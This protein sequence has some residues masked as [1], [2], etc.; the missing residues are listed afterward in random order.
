MKP[1]VGLV[2]T[3]IVLNCVG[4]T[5]F[6]ADFNSG[7]SEDS[8]GN[9][10]WETGSAGVT[11]TVDSKE[12]LLNFSWE[13]LGSSE[14]SN[15]DDCCNEICTTDYEPV[16]ASD[17]V[18]YANYC[19]FSNAQCKTIDL[20]LLALGE[21]AGG[22]LSDEDETGST[23]SLCPD[24]CRDIYDPVS[25]ENGTI[26]TNDCFM[27][28][29]QCN[30]T[31][32]DV[33]IQ[34]EYK[35]LYMRLFKALFHGDSTDD[36]SFSEESLSSSAVAI[37]STKSTTA[38]M[39]RT[40]ETSSASDSDIGSLYEDESNDSIGSGSSSPTTKCIN[41][42]L[43]IY[44]PVCGSDGVSYINVCQLELAACKNPKLNIVR[45]NEDNC[46]DSAPTTAQD[47]IVSEKKP[48]NATKTAL[49]A[50]SM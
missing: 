14:T 34:A 3:A 16:C 47:E 43:D 32:K 1:A 11:P 4:A 31:K 37:T 30:D 22:A 40:M 27:Q 19:A 39:L 41:T 35:K 17:G 45:T 15:S 7:E 13:V 18:T 29:A 8:S 10:A 50:A 24:V 6:S 44:S 23:A 26:Y 2:L 28:M 9:S 48:F 20:T 49:M 38:G 42:C 25:D 21:C 33:D 12:L 5:T 36:D 46:A